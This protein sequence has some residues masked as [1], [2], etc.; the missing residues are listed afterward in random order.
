M[1]ATRRVYFFNIYDLSMFRNLGIRYLCSRPNEKE[2]TSMNITFSAKR[3]FNKR[4]NRNEPSN[5]FTIR[6]SDL[7]GVMVKMQAGDTTLNFYLNTGEIKELVSM[8]EGKLPR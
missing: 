5:S 7:P 1:E 6:C 8:L 2:E 3:L 4:N